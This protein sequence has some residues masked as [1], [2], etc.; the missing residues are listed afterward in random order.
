MKCMVMCQY[1]ICDMHFGILKDEMISEISVGTLQ[2][3]RDRIFTFNSAKRQVSLFTNKKMD[4]NRIEIVI[5]GS[6]KYCG[7]EHEAV[8]VNLYPFIC[9]ITFQNCGHITFIIL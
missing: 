2:I 1:S 5:S 6:C 9:S 3:F 7:S 4:L 8:Y